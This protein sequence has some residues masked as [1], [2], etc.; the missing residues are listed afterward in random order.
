LLQDS[1]SVAFLREIT[2]AEVEQECADDDLGTSGVQPV[3]LQLEQPS[4]CGVAGPRP[5]R[6]ATRAL[7]D[8]AELGTSLLLD[9][10]AQEPPQAGDLGGERIGAGHAAS[11]RLRSVPRRNVRST[12]PQPIEPTADRTFVS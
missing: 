2:E 8:P 6:A 1:D 3:E 11:G 10:V 4:R 7:H 5:D 9:H 12:P